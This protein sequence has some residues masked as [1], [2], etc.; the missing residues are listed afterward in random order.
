MIYLKLLFLRLVICKN[1]LTTLSL[2]ATSV[3]NLNSGILKYYM[4]IRAFS[5]LKGKEHSVD[6]LVTTAC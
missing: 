3:D 6:Y 5:S 2:Q 1:R 4:H